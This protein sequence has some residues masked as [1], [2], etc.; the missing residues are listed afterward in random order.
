MKGKEDKFNDGIDDDDDDGYE[1]AIVFIPEPKVEYEPI[2]VL[3]FNSL[4][5]NIMI[6]RNLSHECM[7]IDKKY[8]NLPGYRYHKTNYKNNDGTIT[9]CK[10]AEKL[11]GTKGIIPRILLALLSAR[12]KYKKMMGDEQ[13]PFAKE[14]YNCLQLAYKVTANS[15][16]GQTG[17]PTSDICMKE[18]A[19]ST[20]SGGRESLLFAKYF[21]EN[22]Y[23]KMIN[24]AL[25]N[26][27]K[28]LKYMHELYEFYPTD[29]VVDDWG[30]DEKTKKKYPISHNIHVCSDINFVIPDNKFV[31]EEIEYDLE[32]PF[33]NK[34]SKTSK[35]YD[36][37][38]TFFVKCGYE[39]VDTYNNKFVKTLYLL[40]VKE[41]KSFLN[42]LRKFMD[43]SKYTL[44]KHQKDVFASMGF[45][46]MDTYLKKFKTATKKLSD[47][48][49]NEFMRLLDDNVN[50]IGYNC[51]DELFEKFYD[52]INTLLKGYD[53]K[54]EIIYGDSVTG[55][56][57]LLL[58]Y[59][60]NGNYKIC[61]LEIQ[62]LGKI[63]NKSVMSNGKLED[64]N[65]K[66]D[67]W[68][69]M[70]WTSIKKVI[71]HKTNKK[72]YN[73]L[74]TNGYVQVTEDHS[75]LDSNGN[76][77][78]P[79]ECDF[80]TN[81]M[82]SFPSEK[83]YNDI[84][85]DKYKFDENN[86]VIIFD[87][88]IEAMKTYYQLK[89]HKYYVMLRFDNT[90]KKIKIIY[91]K[92]NN[93]FEQHGKLKMIDEVVDLPSENWVYDLETENHHFNAGI[94]ELV[95]HNTDSVFFK[96]NIVNKS[97]GEKL[98]NKQ[99]LVLCINLGIWAS[100]MSSALFPPPMKLA[101]EKVLW[102]F[103][104][105][106]KKRYVGNLYELNSNF[107]VQKS[108]GIEIKRRDNAPI[109]KTACSGI[110]H[111]ILN[112]HS[113]EGACEFIKTTLKKVITGKYKMDKFIITKTIKG[114][115]LT[116]KER[117]IEAKKDKEDRSYADRTRIVHAVLAD[118][119]ADRDPG[120]KPMSN[121]RIPYMYTEVEKE[122][123][124]QGDR[125][126]TPEY[127]IDNNLKI[128]YLFYITNQI[129][130]PSLK[131][132]ELIAYNPIDIFKEF[133]IKE[134]NRKNGMMP[135]SYYAERDKQNNVND[136]NFDMIQFDDM[137]NE[138]VSEENIK[139]KRTN[140]SKKKDN[141]K[142]SKNDM[143]TNL[144]NF[145][146]APLENVATRGKKSTSK[147]IKKTETRNVNQDQLFDGF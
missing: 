7:V 5:P 96:M 33:Y 1:G 141:D 78:L 121:D 23:S 37:F 136:D 114:N 98:R 88:Q 17:A 112:N 41:R 125:V 92:S 29:F 83:M 75:L 19:A 118:R 103:I 54:P 16:Y 143:I 59:I 21:V 51:K 15:L 77:V 68:S 55:D 52:T 46:D 137:L 49:K 48:N 72:I 22:M 134:E 35:F 94:G 82:H 34:K 60:H 39:D 67:V 2:P 106:G 11:D 40:K 63:W 8:D 99:G 116:K 81:L 140:K 95:V 3:D 47:D 64:N 111:E 27:K 80:H 129:M 122:P 85:N 44:Y 70:G 90:T 32:C 73:V 84:N 102:P 146:D 14:I 115:A 71:K 105:Q 43:N 109:V 104:I 12:K 61:V 131:F 145:M 56:T 10:F 126:E 4:Y 62:N 66:Y 117:E 38:N 101:Y 25:E 31:A 133:I 108:M 24:F 65:I 113:S 58:R 97:T 91:N 79:L 30:M 127:I 36:K 138:P 69:D 119:M 93:L 110:I 130:K 26:K 142:K 28:Y 124:L 57:P 86:G 100:I 53:T 132:L 89:K 123:E 13:D 42:D 107:F 76:E 74:T 9:H 45:D 120:N 135:I 144:D 139:K 18:I 20:T 6:L 87:S 128:D 50:N 147:K